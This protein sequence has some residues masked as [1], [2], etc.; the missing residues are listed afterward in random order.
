MPG[1]LVSA[2]LSLHVLCHVMGKAIQAF[3]GHTDIA[4][5]VVYVPSDA[6]AGLLNLVV[7]VWVLPGFPLHVHVSSLVA[8][9]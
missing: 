2:L 1:V 9:L 7:E 5:V 8:S 4:V 3:T 6:E